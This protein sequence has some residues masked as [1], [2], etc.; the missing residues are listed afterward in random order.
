MSN[1]YA[2]FHCKRVCE[3]YVWERK[4]QRD[5]SVIMSQL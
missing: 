3:W 5:A 1:E 2:E 4:S